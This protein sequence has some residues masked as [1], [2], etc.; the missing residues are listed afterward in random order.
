MIGF[1]AGGFLHMHSGNEGSNHV[2]N[3]E[4][5]R[6]KQGLNDGGFCFGSEHGHTV[7]QEKEFERKDRVVS[8][9]VSPE[10]AYAAHEEMSDTSSAVSC[11]A[12]SLASEVALNADA[13]AAKDAAAEATACSEADVTA[14]A[15]ERVVGDTSS[16]ATMIASVMKL[17]EALSDTSFQIDVAMGEVLVAALGT[18]SDDALMAGIHVYSVKCITE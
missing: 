4:E 10:V 12:L 16:V 15:A 18:K 3:M 13:F 9:H 1:D 14:T 6:D 8:L 5:M 7:V 11:F 2:L 17:G